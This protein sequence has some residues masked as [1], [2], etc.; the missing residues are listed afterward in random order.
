MKS[1]ERCQL[2]LGSD[3]WGFSYLGALVLSSSISRRSS[4][5]ANKCML[6]PRNEA[7]AIREYSSNERFEGW[8][9]FSEFRSD[10]SSYSPF[11]RGYWS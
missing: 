1:L 5:A 7:T 9:R 6:A 10:F 11:P 4:S 3:L 8:K 2:L